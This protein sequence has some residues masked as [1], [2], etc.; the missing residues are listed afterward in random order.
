MANEKFQILS[1]KIMSE[2]VSAGSGHHSSDI[3]DCRL[4]VVCVEEGVCR[5]TLVV[6]F[7]STSDDNGWINPIIITD[8]N[9]VEVSGKNSTFQLNKLAAGVFTE[10]AFLTE[11]EKAIQVK[12]AEMGLAKYLGE[13]HQEFA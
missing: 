11:V 12:A 10:D 9:E 7:A 1:V 13:P 5:S 8:V 2:I 4:A 6:G 3:G